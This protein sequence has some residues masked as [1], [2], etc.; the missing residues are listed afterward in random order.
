MR[1]AT[2]IWI[3]LL[4]GL[5]LGVTGCGDG[6][7]DGPVAKPPEGAAMLDANRWLGQPLVASNLTVWPVYSSER[8]DIGEFVTLDEAEAQ[9]NALVR[10]V[11]GSNAGQ[12]SAQQMGQIRIAGGPAQ[13][14]VIGLNGAIGQTDAAL[15][16][17]PPP[18][19]PPQQ[20]I[21][22]VLNDQ[23][24][25]EQVEESPETFAP[26]GRNIAPNDN[27][28]P[29]GQQ[30]V[31][32]Q[33]GGGQVAQVVGGNGPTVG[34]LVIE[35]KGDLPILVVAGTIVK[36]GQQDRQI[37][38]D[39]VIAANT[40]VPV[41]AFCV[42]QGRWHSHQAGAAGQQFRNG[43]LGLA[44]KGVRNK[45]QY[46]KD[47]GKVW[48]EV[49][50]TLSKSGVTQTTSLVAAVEKNNDAATKQRASL[51]AQV[52]KHFAQ[53]AGTRE[54]PIGFA[55]AVNGKVETV[56]AFAHP[57]LLADHLPAFAKAMALESVL[58]K[59]AES[60]AVEANDVITFVAEIN[61]AKEEMAQTRGMNV[62]GIR[63]AQDGYNGNC[64]IDA[65]EVGPDKR[66]ILT[67]DWTSR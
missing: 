67:S 10:E 35:N 52:R 50:K 31:A 30:L 15:P 6:P 2:W 37:G 34:T 23:E 32:G 3:L 64:Y 60:K 33:Q 45:A 22:D 20:E 59:D 61:K 21:E 13:N 9:G 41:E 27:R 18:A 7:G 46:E 53:L 36:G 17:P 28:A 19:L 12:Q 39:F 5:V 63:M 62:N 58:S 42:E 49:E 51:E 65:P 14:G 26:R 24:D 4:V 44:I 8:L 25:E 1:D 48:S 43:K 57:R 55:Y 54:Q 47:Q 40:T 66:I 16:S 38:Q 29:R 11:G 56:R